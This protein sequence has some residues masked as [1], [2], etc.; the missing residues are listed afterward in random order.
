MATLFLSRHILQPSSLLK[1]LPLSYWLFL[2]ELRIQQRC[3]I[4]L[5]GQIVQTR[6]AALS[7]MNGNFA[8]QKQIKGPLN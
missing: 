8:S 4:R 2:P 1:S 6:K 5:S 7:Y 3:F